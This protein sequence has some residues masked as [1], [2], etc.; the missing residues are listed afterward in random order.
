MPVFASLNFLEDLALVLSVA[1]LTS[2]VFQKFRQ[3]VVVGY[4]VA[5]MIVGPHLP[6]PLLADQ[7]RIHSIAD[8]GVILLMFGLGLEFSL[9]KL[10]RLLPTAGFITIVQVGLLFW[11]GYVVGSAFGWTRLESIFAGGLL[12]ISSTTIIA[13]GFAEEKVEQGLRE[14]VFG[15]TL[16]ED[17]AAVILLT[18]LTALATGAGLSPR[19]LMVTVGHL[20]AFLA[21]IVIIGVLLVPPLVRF[22]VALDRDE[23]LIVA[24]VGICFAFSMIADKAGYS[25]ALGAFIAGVLVSESGVSTG[26]ERLVAPLQD[27]FG[28]V[29][30]VSVGMMLDPRSLLAYWP[31]LIAL[32]IVVLIGKFVGVTVSALLSGNSTKVAVAAGMSMAQIGEFSFII[33]GVGVQHGAARNFL[34]SL[35]IA[36]SAITTFITPFMIRGALRV[37][38]LVE[39]RVPH[40]L[41]ISQSFY[42]SIIRGV[43]HRFRLV[44][45]L[46]MVS[47][48]VGCAL[49]LIGIGLGYEYAGDRLTLLLATRA[50]IDRSLA[51]RVVELLILSFGLVPLLGI[52]YASHELARRLATTIHACGAAAVVCEE[53]SRAIVHLFEV[54]ILLMMVT[55]ML[56]LTAPFLH[57][58][59]GVLVLIVAAVGLSLMAWQSAKQ[60]Q[61]HRR[62]VSDFLGSLLS[63]H[64]RTPAAILRNEQ[65]KDFGAK[66]D[67]LE[68]VNV[69]ENA[70]TVGRTLGELNLRVLTGAAVISVVR[71]ETGIPCP[72]S[73]E[74]LRAG[75]RLTLAGASDAL[76][77]ARQLIEG[78]R[79]EENAQVRA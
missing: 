59:D 73:T 75:D 28:A 19:A 9:H 76:A 50:D 54:P 51:Q 68:R 52:R 60:I 16:F 13:K 20:S 44:S 41:G 5:G 58:L 53:S 27:I 36:I 18:I 30:F 66:I 6:I 24:S 45:H 40:S 64:I 42:K 33:A 71:G 1:A 49:V 74:V 3:P 4:L 31:A 46:N 35:A 56:A 34:Y 23:T 67:S 65:F 32:V 57:S 22:I 39:D 38:T 37:G 14:L 43:H 8:L 77:A 29:F 62:E 25:V 55:V 63:R 79:V 12:G 15:V 11:L 47:F 78:H 61:S 48:L 72:E 10:W 69:P 17:L 70:S 21:A 7:A 2:I 26:V